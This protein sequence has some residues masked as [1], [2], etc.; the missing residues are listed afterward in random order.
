MLQ[1]TNSTGT[2]N[3]HFTGS[4]HSKVA[5]LLVNNSVSEVFKQQYDNSN[6]ILGFPMVI[7]LA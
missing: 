2:H 5:G 4:G 3:R 7:Y 1:H 6:S